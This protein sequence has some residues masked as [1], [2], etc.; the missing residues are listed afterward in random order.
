MSD[1]QDKKDQFQQSK[2]KSPLVWVVVALVVASAAAAGAWL[3]LGGSAS[4]FARVEAQNGKVQIPVSRVDDGKAHFFTYRDGGTDINFF[5]IK[6]RDGVIRAAFDACDVC[7]KDK[8][9]YR[10]EGN[11]M[12]C[13]NCEQT[14]PTE[15][16]NV[17]KGGCNPAPLVR[18]VGSDHIMIAAADLKKGA[19]YFPGK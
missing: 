14:F 11:V 9:G 16:I 15:R 12:V 1:R 17:V 18:L 6:S 7:Y 3:S 4:A 8:R 10:Q 2:K 13:N 19:W 5:L